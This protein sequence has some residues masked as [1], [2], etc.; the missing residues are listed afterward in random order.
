MTKKQKF[1]AYDLEYAMK[2]A[3]V[4]ILFLISGSGRAEEYPEAMYEICPELRNCT[5]GCLN[6][7]N[8]FHGVYL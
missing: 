4:E 5:P 2:Q 6:G 7:R 8:S 1:M 3:E